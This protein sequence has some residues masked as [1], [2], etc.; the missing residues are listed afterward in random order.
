MVDAHQKLFG[1]DLFK[2]KNIAVEINSAFGQRQLRETLRALPIYTFYQLIA[3]VIMNFLVT[4]PQ[5]LLHWW[6]LFSAFATLAIVS[7]LFAIRR[8]QFD[9]M[10]A[11]FLQKAMIVIGLVMAALWSVPVLDFVDQTNAYV[12]LMIFC[13]TLSVWALG[14]V[15]WL[16]M[17]SVAV[18]YASFVGV[19]MCWS[20]YSSFS[21]HHVLLA[22]ACAAFWVALIGLV[23]TAHQ[24]FEKR[25]RADIES[26]R[27]S[28]I[29]TLLL[30]DFTR[31][32]R[33][34]LWET[35]VN[36]NLN[37]SS[38][39]LSDVL[40]LPENELHKLVFLAHLQKLDT[41]LPEFSISVEDTLDFTMCPTINEHVSYW[42][43]KARALFDEAGNFNGYRGVGRDVTL[44][45]LAE[46]Q[47]LAAK[48]AAESASAA[49]SQFLAVISHELRT[50]I[51]AIVGF[52]EVLNAEHAE[53]LSKVDRKIYLSSII[54]SAHHLQNL[55]SDILDA[56]RL[57]R[58]SFKLV[59]QKNDCA[60]ILEAALK[61]CRSQAEAANIS[62]VAHIIDDVEVEGDLTR[63]KQVLLNLIGNAIKFSPAGSVVNVDMQKGPA[64]QLI[65]AVRDAGIG[66]SAEDAAR[67]F[68]P[69]VQI[70]GG[71]TRNFGGMGLGLAIARQIARLHD[72]DVTLEGLVGIGTEAKLILPARRVAWRA[73]SANKG[74]VAA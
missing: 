46:V 16:R 65:I 44:Q 25:T 43:I 67:V 64:G 32:A 37:Y 49:K 2:N 57:E 62:I 33:D 63:L 4:G 45:H 34:W 72:G 71:S 50:P 47:I 30:N 31:E 10:G 14:V 66:I 26:A 21:E 13:I 52:S 20:I 23:L 55:I 9:R 40:G 22:F 6:Q 1:S 35:D 19:V 61:M 74:Q 51:N 42:Q 59:E 41:A 70:D 15:A 12:A 17:P 54:E 7:L 28:E 38:P 11:A 24:E 53:H 8:F 48:E 5:A 18:T 36:G 56:T 58:G 60:E 73:A 27:H 39:R 3:A 69:F 29:I 68:E